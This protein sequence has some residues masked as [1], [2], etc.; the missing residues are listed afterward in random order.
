LDNI[1]IS[2]S[3]NEELRGMRKLIIQHAETVA[4]QSSQMEQEEE[5]EK[6]KESSSSSSAMSTD[7]IRPSVSN[8]THEG[9]DSNVN[10]I[11]QDTTT[12]VDN[13]NINEQQEQPT[14]DEQ[15]GY[16]SSTIANSGLPTNAI[17]S[18]TPIARITNAK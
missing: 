8:N 17:P 7:P 9:G 16:A 2:W 10:K 11:N 12:I 5:E 3:N 4:Q 18:S 6:K 1:D 14:I 13:N 15:Q